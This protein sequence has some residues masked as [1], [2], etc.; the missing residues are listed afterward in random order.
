MKT[1]VHVCLESMLHEATV[2]LSDAIKEYL[3]AQ[4]NFFENNGSSYRF[5]AT[6]KALDEAYQRLSDLEATKRIINEMEE[7]GIEV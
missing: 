3:D 6:K 1:T 2:T 5:R 7:K 4:K